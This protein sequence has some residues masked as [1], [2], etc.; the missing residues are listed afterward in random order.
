MK[1]K[2]MEDTSIRTG[3][4]GGFTRGGA[5]GESSKDRRAREEERRRRLRRQREK[6]W[7]DPG[8]GL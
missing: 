2:D 8:D 7:R 5:R 3:R 4:E 1:R 6:P